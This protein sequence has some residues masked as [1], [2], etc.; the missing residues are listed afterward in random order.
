VKK[1]FAMRS[2]QFSIV[3]FWSSWRWMDAMFT[4]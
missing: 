1:V 2:R 4:L 3:G